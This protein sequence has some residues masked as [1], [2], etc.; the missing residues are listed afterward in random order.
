MTTV[1]SAWTEV[2]GLLIH[3]R[4]S[5]GSPPAAPV[6]VLVHGFIISSRYMAPL[7]ERLSPSFNVYAP[8]LP[9]FGWSESPRRLLGLDELANSLV[10]W[11]A[12][13]DLPSVSLL[14]NSF[15]CQVI[16]EFAARYPER[17]ER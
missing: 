8:D 15:G 14:G 16:A 13:V 7:A 17:V 5:V 2:D 3:S 1:T 6:V 11:M 4:V 12:A 9:G 10:A